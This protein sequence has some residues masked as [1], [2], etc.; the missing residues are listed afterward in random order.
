MEWPDLELEI[1]SPNGSIKYPSIHK[2]ISGLTFTTAFGLGFGQASFTVVRHPYDLVDDLV[3][4]NKVRILSGSDVPWEG[5][6]TNRGVNATG[7]VP[8]VADGY[9][10]RLSSRLTTTSVGAER[11]SSWIT[12]NILGDTDLGYQAGTI[13]YGADFLFP[14]GI[15]LQ[16]EA[17]YLD[18]LDKINAPNGYVIAVWE[19]KTIH[20]HPQPVNPQYIVRTDVGELDLNFLMEGIENYLHVTYSLD[21][22]T[23]SYFWWPSDGPDPDSA[24][25]YHR[26]DGVLVVPGQSSLAQAQATAQVALNWRKRIRPMSDFIAY[27]VWDA[28]TG[29]EVNPATLRCGFV[30]YMENL[31]PSEGT[32][33]SKAIMNDVSTFMVVGTKYDRTTGLP[34][35]SP[36][37]RGLTIENLLAR[38]QARMK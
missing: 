38:P 16:P 4:T 25:L 14:Y 34:T 21:G 27:R 3:L 33:A 18:A 10:H 17:F 23:P 35:L 15:N 5:E 6:I 20:F 2:D 8:I 1:S 36:G 24:S 13:N 30:V 31:F 12:N 19:D 22:S 32:L 29:Q 7:S 37:A 28:T 26:R 11:G 9:G